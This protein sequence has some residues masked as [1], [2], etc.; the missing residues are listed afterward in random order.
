MMDP[1]QDLEWNMLGQLG[2]TLNI[3]IWFLAQ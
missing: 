2:Y 3:M 1:I